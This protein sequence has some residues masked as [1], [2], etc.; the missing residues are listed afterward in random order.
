MYS[1]VYKGYAVFLSFI[2]RSC[3]YN[4][5]IIIIVF[6]GLEDSPPSKDTDT[7]IDTYTHRHRHPHPPIKI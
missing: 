1:L 3:F 4:I 5:S 7:H 6:K 2:L